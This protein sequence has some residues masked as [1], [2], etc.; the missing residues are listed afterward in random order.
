MAYCSN[1]GEQA[2]DE[3]TFCSKCGAAVSGREGE[4]HDNNRQNGPNGPYYGTPGGS[5]N[6]STVSTL[7]LVWG[8]LAIIFGAFYLISNVIIGSTAFLIYD[9]NTPIGAFLII[10]GL[11]VSLLA[12]ISGVLGIKTRSNINALKSFKTT[13]NYCLYGSI[14]ALIDG[15]ALFFFGGFIFAILFLAA[16]IIGI[17]FAMQLKKEGSYFLS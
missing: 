11:I 8:I 3:S 9:L 5:S 7:G 1:C 16:G 4:T 6:L 2:D 12:I 15:I 14:L 13:C 10:Y 17:V